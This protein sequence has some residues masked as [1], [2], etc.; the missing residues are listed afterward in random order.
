MF[1][2]DENQHR[3]KRPNLFSSTH[4]SG[5]A[6]DNIL[7]RLERG[8]PSAAPGERSTHT[9][10]VVMG[11]SGLL[12]AGLIGVL[13][14]L[15]QDNRTT[16]RQM[17]VVASVASPP[18]PLDPVHE[19]LPE[20]QPEPVLADTQAVI[21]DQAE[22]VPPLVTATV[23][24]PPPRVERS[25][26]SVRP[27]AKP[28]SKVAAGPRKAARP[29]PATGESPADIDVTILAAILSQTPRHASPAPDGDAP[30]PR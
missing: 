25:A 1:P 10:M 28:V 7:A 14:I 19:S 29:S 27:P 8:A 24:P 2:S 15:A 6:D 9:R 13:I 18:L 22:T 4:R 20:P 16:P 5:A 30:K 26:A 21:V 12:V 23:R 11:F 3:A 17:E